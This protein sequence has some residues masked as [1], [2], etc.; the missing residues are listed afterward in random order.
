MPHN[1]A[2]V[3][4]ETPAESIPNFAHAY[5]FQS[6]GIQFH[7]GFCEACP[8][9]HWGLVASSSRAPSVMCPWAP[10]KGTLPGGAATPLAQFVRIQNPSLPLQ[11]NYF[12]VGATP[13]LRDD[14]GWGYQP[15]KWPIGMNLRVQVLEPAVVF[16]GHS[17]PMIQNR[18]F[19]VIFFGLTFPNLCEEG[20]SQL[21]LNFAIADRCQRAI[22]GDIINVRELNQLMPASSDGDLRLFGANTALD[23]VEVPM[24]LLGRRST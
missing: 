24:L 2:R 10:A 8:D 23:T 7:L 16:E 1:P 11:S 12:V 14:M 19:Q 21:C 17:E 20:P 6:A 5:L 4:A 3:P 9:P 18:K 13:D 22:I 15:G